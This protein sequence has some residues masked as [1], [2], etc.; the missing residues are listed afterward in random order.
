MRYSKDLKKGHKLN[1]E[2]ICLK[3]PMEGILGDKIK[4]FEGKHLKKSVRFEECLSY[5]HI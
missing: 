1:S 4:D 2:D 5:E 3:R